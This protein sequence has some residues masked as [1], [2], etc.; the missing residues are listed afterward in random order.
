MCVCVCVCVCVFVGVVGTGGEARGVWLPAQR[1]QRSRCP[2][3]VL[4]A[5]AHACPTRTCTRNLT[6]S[7][8]RFTIAMCSAVWPS[9][10]PGASC[11]ER[12]SCA[13]RR[14]ERGARRQRAGNAAG[15]AAWAGLDACACRRSCQHVSTHT[16]IVARA[17]ACTCTC[18]CTRARAR[19]WMGQL[20]SCAPNSFTRYLQARR[21]AGRQAGR[22]AGRRARTHVCVVRLGAITPREPWAP[23]QPS[24][25]HAARASA[26]EAA[27]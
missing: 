5:H 19:T 11:G 2:A 20:T 25:L 8:S 4:A 27:L 9:Y 13:A 16:C 3:A 12:R 10:A 22:H 26:P 1:C 24:Q 21:Q 14:A 23:V 6:M 17:G 7:K 15:R 18:A